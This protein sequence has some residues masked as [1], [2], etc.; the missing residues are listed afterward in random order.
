MKISLIIS[1]FLAISLM[2]CSS[3]K[4]G[5][6]SPAFD[7]K[8]TRTTNL[9]GRQVTTETTKLSGIEMSESLNEDGTAIVNRPYK[10]YAGI[11]K[12]DDKSTAIEIAQREAYST[13]SRLLNNAV[14]DQA[15]RGKIAN[16]GRVQQALTSHWK[17]FSATLQKGCEPFGSSA[18][19]YD[20]STRMYEATCK[21]AI[22]GDIFNQLLNTAGNFNPSDLKGDELEQFIEA[23]KA[24]MEAAKGN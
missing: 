6:K 21:I 9:E 12:A 10:W 19:E 22:R 3:S 4:N 18:I 17:Q 16:N 1:M 14:Q 24:I 7:S 2:S 20:P 11:R 15:E 8:T 23:N 13:I 5:A